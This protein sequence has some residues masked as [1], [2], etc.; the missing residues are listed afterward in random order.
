[1]QETG[2]NMTNKP[3][4]HLQKTR[5]L[6]AV[7]VCTGFSLLS[8]A[9]FGELPE[10]ASPSTATGAATS[11]RFY[12]GVTADD[13]LSYG[14][15]FGGDQSL[16]I[17][18][19]IQVQPEHINTVGN[20]YLL[21][22]LGADTLMR[23]ESGD[24]VPWDGTLGSLQATSPGKTLQAIEP[25]TV[26][27]NTPLGPAGLAGAS[28]QIFLAYDT[29]AAPGQLYY[30]GAPLSFGI[31]AE[32][33]DAASFTFYVANIS[34]PIVQNSC[35]V[36]HTSTGV[37]ATSAL[38]YVNSTVE[39]YQQSNYNA[40]IDYIENAPNGSSLI[41]SKPQ[42]TL[43]GGGVQLPPGSANLQLWSDFVASSLNDIASTGGSTGT[44][45]NIFSAVAKMDN[46]Q[47]L[48]KA[49]LLFAGRLPTTQETNSVLGVSEEELAASI[50]G[51]MS[52]DGFENFLIES[53]NNRLLTEALTGNVFGIVDRYRYPNSYQYYQTPGPIGSDK[54]LTA[55]ALAL[56][57]MKLVAHVVMNERPY[58][59]VLTA[60]YVMVNPYSAEVY[61]GNITFD[62]ASDP[63][64][65]REGR[66][67]EYYRCTVCSQQ[68]ETAN[69]NIS[70]DYP[71]AGILNSP[72]FLSRFPSTETNRNRARARWAY[73]FF[74]GVDIEGLS[75]RTTDPAALADENN[76][77][78]NN[79]NC[80]VC[81]NIMDPVAGAF[82]N[83]GNKGFY[84]DQPGGNN[85][86]PGSYRNDHSGTYQIGDN[87]YADM[88]AP[89]FGEKL[90]PSTDNS[91]QWLAQEFVTDSRFGY[92]TVYFW[93]PAVMGRDAYALPEN[94]EDFDYQS[95]LAA[96]TAEQ[97]MM[98]S[99][100]QEFVSGSAG[101]GNHNLKDLLVD[102][103]L[104]DHFRAV[105]VSMLTTQ[106]EAELEDVGSGKLLTP[107]QL[108]RKLLSTAGFNWNYGSKS[109]L[110]VVYNLIYGGIDSFGITERAT[111]L[112]TLMSSV[113]TAMANEVSCPITAQDFGLAQNQRKLFPFVELTSLP[114]TNASAVRSN[115][116]YLHS[117]LLGEEL[118]I[119]DPEIDATFSL[120][121]AVWNARNAANK[122]AAVSS[123]SELCIVSGVVNPVTSD[124]NQT[125]RSWAAVVNFM[126]RDYNFI[127]E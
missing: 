62:D 63:D 64:E 40:L 67:T 26:A 39:G 107:E 43:H 56:E 5:S 105:S 36:C 25:L 95:K 103:V 11:A 15:S 28:L 101:N 31:E 20:L 109:A 125:L 70:T 117:R 98:Q 80:T 88:L 42:G 44:A 29:T 17:L 8:T 47:T 41:L 16:D 87:W 86:L 79:P 57:P 77:T 12:G 92:G 38:H 66:I 112:T 37:A 120:F 50:R 32:A 110:E 52:G 113:V 69:Y 6:L 9:L 45:Q 2:L 78:L 76:P 34:T 68:P 60:D 48:R 46:G 59:E 126:I 114:T 93:Y 49:A 115:I 123:E 97:A 100:A 72:A 27:E 106:Q 61:G 102:L 119:N 89:G 30:S 73:Y 33:S 3:L 83:Y 96:Y 91:L 1:M 35:I 124:P 127:H 75:E 51:L 4:L 22:V 18:T 84:K 74:L 58:T 94:P 14:A 111:D 71:H 81:H 54:Q 121:Q 108:N 53:A 21:A 104:S 10:L 116:Q 7:V 85:S 122:G 13:G 19:E 99:I 65:W 23:V 82:Q 90:A 118:A 24:F 55:E